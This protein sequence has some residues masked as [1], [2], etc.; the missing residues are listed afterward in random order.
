MAAIWAKKK[1]KKAKVAYATFSLFST[2]T[3]TVQNSQPHVVINFKVWW[4]H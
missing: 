4:Q 3:M 1:K 2:P